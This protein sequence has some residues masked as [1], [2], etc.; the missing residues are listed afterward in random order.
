MMATSLPFFEE[1]L[2]YIKE[3]GKPKYV[4][5]PISTFE[6]LLELIEDLQDHRYIEE[7]KSD[8]LNPIPLQEALKELST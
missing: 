7:A 5:F 6:K 3:N 2:Q 8:G 1:N 4:V